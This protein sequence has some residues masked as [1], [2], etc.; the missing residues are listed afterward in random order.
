MALG[1][2]SGI[3]NS[4]LIPV[5]PGQAFSP[6]TFGQA[7]TGPGHWP[8]NGVYNVPPVQAAPGTWS[9]SNAMDAEGGHPAPTAGSITPEGKVSFFSPTK[10]PLVMALLFLAAGLG[11][12]HFIH[13]K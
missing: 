6:L 13:Y 11:M 3:V 4:Q 7:Y 5:A 12:L 8:R 1:Y 2:E 9:G 10:S